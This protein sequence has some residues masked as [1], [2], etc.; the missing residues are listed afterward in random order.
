MHKK[1][2]T[3]TIWGHPFPIL[4]RFKLSYAILFPDISEVVAEIV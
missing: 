4:L 1:K 3:I 2:K